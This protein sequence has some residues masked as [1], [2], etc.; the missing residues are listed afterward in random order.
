MKT[1]IVDSDA[2]IAIVNK[3]DLMSSK[4]IKT[5]EN[6]YKQQAK[7]IYPVTT[8]A[9]TITTLQRKLSN[10]KLAAEVNQMIMDSHFS[11][12]AVD[13]EILYLAQSIFNPK[14]S[15]QNTFFDAIVAAVAKKL[16]ADAI[17]SF[18]VW[19]QKSGFTLASNLE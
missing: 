12:A 2:L 16:K 4:A 13:Q 5:L 17:F 7:L 19:Y 6:L 10:P 14:G 8:I 18:D 15:K 11:I 1:I 9:E 3:D